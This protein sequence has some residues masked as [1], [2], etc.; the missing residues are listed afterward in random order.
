MANEVPQ[1]SWGEEQ[2][3]KDWRRDWFT[4]E[5]LLEM[6]TPD[7]HAQ[8]PSLDSLL[9]DGQATILFRPYKCLKSTTAIEMTLAMTPAMH[10][11]GIAT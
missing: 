7:I 4:L 11:Y 3:P 8:R 9:P 6:D 10:W 5:E 1:E 2:A